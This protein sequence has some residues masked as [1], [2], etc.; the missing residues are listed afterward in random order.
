MNSQAVPDVEPSL[1]G[2]QEPRKLDTENQ[3]I[4]SIY[5]RDTQ[6]NKMLFNEG[7]LQTSHCNVR[8]EGQHWSH[9]PRVFPVCHPLKGY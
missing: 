4:N 5:K 7:L 2:M 6:Y 1:R 8:P 9:K 3:L